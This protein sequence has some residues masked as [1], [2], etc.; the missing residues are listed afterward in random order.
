MGDLHQATLIDGYTFADRLTAPFEQG[1]ARSWSDAHHDLIRLLT[2]N[3]QSPAERAFVKMALCRH[4]ATLGG[5]SEAATI[6]ADIDLQ[7]REQ[8][9][10]Q[11]LDEALVWCESLPHVAE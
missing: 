1:A 6:R 7:L 9:L 4:A 2:V 10:A 11:S 5:T 3:A 8:H